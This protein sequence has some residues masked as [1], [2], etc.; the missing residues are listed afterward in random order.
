MKLHFKSG[1][2]GIR[3]DL[4]EN[5]VYAK[6]IYKQIKYQSLR[7][8]EMFNN[9]SYFNSSLWD[10]ITGEYYRSIKR[11]HSHYIFDYWKWNEKR[12]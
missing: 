6:G 2:L 7:I 12:N 4:N 1:Y 8:K 10:T 9:P 11:S 5:S 3:P